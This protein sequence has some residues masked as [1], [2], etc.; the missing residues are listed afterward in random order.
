VGVDLSP[1]GFPTQARR[2]QAH[3]DGRRLPF[4]DG[5]MDG[6]VCSNLL[7]HTPD[8]SAIFHEIA[9]VLKPG[10]WAWV[11]WTNW[12]SPWG[13]HEI[14]PLHYLGPE[15][16]LRTW[17]RFFGEP[18]K[19]VPFDGLWPTYVSQMLQIAQSHPALELRGAFPRYY[20][21]QRWIVRTPGVREVA[22]W[23]CVLQLE[24]RRNVTLD[25]EPPLQLT[26]P[27]P[28]AALRRGMRRA[29]RKL[30]DNPAFLPVLLRGTPLGMSRRITPETELVIEG[31][32]RSGN[33][34]AHFAVLH[35]EP[36][37]VITSRVHAPAQV[38]AALQQGVP[39]LL[40]IREPVES[41]ASA[42]VASAHVP[43]STLLF[44]Y[45]HFYEE[46]YPLLDRLVVATFD[47]IVGD[48]DQVVDA[49]NERFQV[50]FKPFGHT[51]EHVDAVFES[52]ARHHREH[53]G[54]DESR[55]PLPVDSQRQLKAR[56]R[57]EVLRPEFASLLQEAQTVYDTVASWSV[58]STGRSR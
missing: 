35:A 44:E 25:A 12:Y 31:F 27:G 30:G 55:L 54:D 58:S 28:R 47:E 45:V 32:P 9:R 7:E 34:F 10:G 52:I 49:L 5:S 57:D 50:G 6:V 17:R 56:V 51:P 16:G 2:I 39:T 29:Q 19:N 40:T 3:A 24:R 4:A 43:I 48:F 20:P 11:S 37:A 13:G 15:R 14:V 46:L 22:S 21:S 42:A 26:L 1:E 36:G 41:I 53:W 33:T 38:K 18:R 23:N 8:P